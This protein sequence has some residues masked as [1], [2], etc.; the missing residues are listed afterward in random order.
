MS[1]LVETEN[2]TFP[3]SPQDYLNTF[4]FKLYC[5]ALKIALALSK[6]KERRVSAP[7]VI[8]DI[9]SA[10]DF[11][12]TLKLEQFV[13]TIFKTYD[14]VLQDKLSLQLILL[15]HDEMVQGAFRR[16]I[17]LRLEEAGNVQLFQNDSYRDHFL[18]GRLFDKKDWTEYLNNVKCSDTDKFINLYLE[19]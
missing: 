7:I 13:Y 8:D 17:K 4:R 6:M 12:N 14:E 16:G 2:G 18:C 19:N 11:E 10:S 9:F 1:I 5:V 15:T 3:A